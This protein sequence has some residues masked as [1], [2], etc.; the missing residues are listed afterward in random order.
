ML[1]F[2]PDMISQERSL[3]MKPLQ[4]QR[5]LTA[6][7]IIAMLAVLAFFVAVVLTLFPIYTEHLSVVS[8]LKGLKQ[9][10]ESR[11]MTDKDMIKTMMRRFDIDNVK[12][13]TEDN[14]TIARDSDS[15][16]VTIDYEV[17]DHFMAN[18]DVVAVFHDEV[19]IPR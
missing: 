4:R 5:G 18:I 15:T 2:A 13:V 9:D 8:H 14:I 3:Y 7:S 10:S 11:T 16:S 19:E 6:I 12:N 1:D 17:R